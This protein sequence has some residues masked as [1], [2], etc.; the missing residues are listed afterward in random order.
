MS[1]MHDDWG[2]TAT[3]D[4]RRRD[5]AAALVERA[6][7][8]IY[9]A[10]TGSG[11]TKADTQ[12][13]ARSQRVNCA[14][15]VDAARGGVIDA[16]TQWLSA[17]AS[18]G[19]A[20]NARAAA[21]RV[22]KLADE[23]A[24]LQHSLAEATG[25]LRFERTTNTGR[26]IADAAYLA[27]AALREALP[28]LRFAGEAAIRMKELAPAD[29]RGRAGLAGSLREAP[30]DEALALSLV[31]LWAS[32]GLSAAGGRAGDGLDAFLSELLGDKAA[33]KAITKARNS[34]STK[35]CTP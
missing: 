6:L 12:W 3:Y 2:V 16:V 15:A 29:A 34:A 22:A 27:E 11:A 19:P 9:S 32:H 4:M 18:A 23:I 17:K 7:A 33:E 31:H 26:E 21:E 5:E 8:A 10:R 30:P 35:I 25:A 24:S 13:R 20:Q 28:A 1:E 14:F